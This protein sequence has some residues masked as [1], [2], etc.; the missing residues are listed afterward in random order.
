MPTINVAQ[1]LQEPVGATR[2][3]A[4]HETL[5]PPS[6][7]VALR[8]PAEGRLKL[9]HTQR[10]ILVNARYKL[11]IQVECAR[12]VDPVDLIIGGAFDEEFLQM[13]DLRSG[14]PRLDEEGEEDRP[15]VNERHE[16]ELGD[17][18]RQDVLTRLPMRPLCEEACPGL[19]AQCG[20]R[21][22]ARHAAHP[23]DDQTDV[24][25][26]PPDTHQPFARLAELLGQADDEPD[27]P[28]RRAG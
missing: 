25:T 9:T 23:E 16:V 21:L 4:F 20:Q 14:L 24:T 5:R 13:T 15:R 2:D 12:C 17:V 27:Q 18:L 10:G 8:G 11:P 28:R 26:A 6:E 3:L 22:D 7:A 19:C 1:L